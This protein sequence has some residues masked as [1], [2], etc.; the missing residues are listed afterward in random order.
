MRDNLEMHVPD[1]DEHARVLKMQGVTQN[2]C[3]KD[4]KPCMNTEYECACGSFDV[5]GKCQIG[6]AFK[7]DTSQMNL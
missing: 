2:P 7:G 3:R 6:K 1:K 4:K 5:K